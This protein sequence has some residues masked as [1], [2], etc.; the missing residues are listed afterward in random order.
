[1]SPKYESGKKDRWT[2]PREASPEAALACFARDDK[3]AF[4]HGL[5][6]C[7]DDELAEFVLYQCHPHDSREVVSRFFVRRVE[8]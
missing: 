6:L 4:P 5:R 1:M 8:L 3:D 7:G 2:L